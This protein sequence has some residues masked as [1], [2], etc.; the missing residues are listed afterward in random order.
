M[1]ST[2]GTAYLCVAD[3]EGMAVS[4]IQSNYQGTGSRFGA[5]R[6][7][8]LLQ[9]RGL[10]FN[11]VPGHPN[12]LAPGKRPLHTLSPTLWTDSLGPRWALGTRGGSVQPQLVAQMGALAILGGL[13]LETA[14][15]TP[16]WTVADFGPGT[17]SHPRLEPGLA[18]TVVDGLKEAGHDVEEMGDRQAG[19]GPV[20]VIRIDGARRHVAADPRVDTT[21]ALAF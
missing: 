18:P 7:G 16:R 13:D 4:I 10:G 15:A 8:F 12:E 20:S 21:A 11:L 19:W 3:D 6:S 2:G 1:G 17:I 9:D 14:Q 5:E